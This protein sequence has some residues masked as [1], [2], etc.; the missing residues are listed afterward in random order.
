MELQYICSECGCDH[1]EPSDATLG[2][3]NIC[4]DC[5]VMIEAPAA[6]GAGA[7]QWVVP[8]GT[9]ATLEMGIRPPIAA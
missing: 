5:A 3:R 1:N 4:L 6:L 9:K 2:H 8:C 7:L